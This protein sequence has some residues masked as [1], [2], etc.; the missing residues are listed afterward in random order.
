VRDANIQYAYN[1]Y[2]SIYETK[3]ITIGHISIN[4][5]NG[6]EQAMEFEEAA[7]QIWKKRRPI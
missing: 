1:E 2:V 6:Y 3:G 4:E 7:L 5:L